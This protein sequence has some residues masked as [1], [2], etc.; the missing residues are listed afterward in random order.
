VQR[1]LRRTPFVFF[2]LRGE[3][4][5]IRIMIHEHSNGVV[6]VAHPDDETLWAGGTLLLH[7]DCCWTVVTLTRGSDA[8]RAA[9]FE[10]AMEHYGATGLMGDLDDGPEQRP[11]ST[12]QVEDAIMDLL[13]A[14]RYDLVLTHAPWGEYTRHRRHEEVAQAVMALHESGQLSLGEIQM[15][16]YQDDGGRHLSRAAEDAD[17]YVRLP[18]EIWERKYRI[19]TDVYG[20]GPDSFEARTTPKEEAFWV[21]GKGK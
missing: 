5:R 21:M 20:F 16:A 1:N 17:V 13:P 2:G 10:K 18:E 19:V 9:R 6:L 7:P 15:F 8:E 3:A 14:H 11:L 12:V 4:V